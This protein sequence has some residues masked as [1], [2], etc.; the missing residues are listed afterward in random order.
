ME[1]L[2][3]RTLRHYHLQ[4]NS[5]VRKSGAFRFDVKNKATG[6]SYTYTGK[7]ITPKSMGIFSN[8]VEKKLAS[9]LEGS[10]LEKL[11]KNIENYSMLLNTDRSL[12]KKSS[13]YENMSLCIKAA[14]CMFITNSRL[15]SKAHIEHVRR[16]A[17]FAR[18]AGMSTD[19]ANISE[20]FNIYM[21]RF[22]ALINRGS[23]NETD[24]EG[25]LSILIAARSEGYNPD[26]TLLQDAIFPVLR[27]T[28]KSLKISD[29]TLK[30]LAGH[31]NIRY[32][33]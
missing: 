6:Y 19:M 18:M 5:N 23:F 3:T 17:W 24:A 13:F 27:G 28:G 1:I 26:I 14:K 7:D 9:C 31:L 22:A 21:E 32:C 8:W 2:N 4:Y 11:T 10:A 29:E 16:L 20:I 12:A 15:T 30:T 33:C 25:L